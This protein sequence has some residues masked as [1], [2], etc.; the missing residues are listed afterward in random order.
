MA[1]REKYFSVLEILP[2]FKLQDQHKTPTSV[3]TFHKYS[4][5]YV[6]ASNMDLLFI[7]SMQYNC[8]SMFLIRVNCKE[9]PSQPLLFH[10]ELIIY[11]IFKNLTMV[12]LLL[13]QWDDFQWENSTEVSYISPTS[14]V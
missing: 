6:S 8:L 10:I 5:G 14:V 11:L 3:F 13:F 1:E 7:L 2:E 12:K 4:I 9:D